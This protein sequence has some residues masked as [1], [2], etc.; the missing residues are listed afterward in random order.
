MTQPPLTEKAVLITDLQLGRTQVYVVDFAACNPS[1]TLLRLEPHGPVLHTEF[2]WTTVLC[3][4]DYHQQ[5]KIFR[6]RFK[7]FKRS[8]LCF[9][10]ILN[11]HSNT[12]SKA[13]QNKESDGK[14]HI[15]HLHTYCVRFLILKKTINLVRTR[16]LLVKSSSLQ[17]AEI[18]SL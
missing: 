3:F 7:G 1:L 11:N 13:I 6:S 16:F 14:S 4:L 8:C 12:P 10:M 5:K 18:C 9:L 15:V 17:N 2:P